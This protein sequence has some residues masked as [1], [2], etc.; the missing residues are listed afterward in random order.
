MFDRKFEPK[1]MHKLG[2]KFSLQAIRLRSRIYM[3]N[4][5]F[6]DS[7]A[8]LWPCHMLCWAYG[9]DMI[10]IIVQLFSIFVW[11]VLIIY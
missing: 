2:S 4:G 9:N 8:K 5:R 1:L 11:L 7:P 3:H 6:W 10:W